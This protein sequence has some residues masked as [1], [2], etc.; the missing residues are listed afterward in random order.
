MFDYYVRQLAKEC[1]MISS[2]E[3]PFLTRVLPI[4]LCNDLVLQG[5]LYFAGTQYP[6]KSPLISRTAWT[7]FAQ[8]V[9]GLKFGLTTLREDGEKFAGTEALLLTSY[10]LLSAEVRCCAGLFQK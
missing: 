4:A 7:H 5:L 3:N 10:F 2:E 8:A 9:R 1:S 6:I